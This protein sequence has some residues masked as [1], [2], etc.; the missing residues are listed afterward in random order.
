MTK[1]YNTK[2]FYGTVSLKEAMIISTGEFVHGVA[3][4]VYILEAEEICGF[5]PADREANWVARVENKEGSESVTI[6]GC[7][8]RGVHQHEKAKKP[9]RSVYTVGE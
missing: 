9:L 8:I 3:G 4:F 7:Q 6:L 2:K 5:K 1:Q